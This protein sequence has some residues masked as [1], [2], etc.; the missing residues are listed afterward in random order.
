MV[1]NFKNVTIN[2]KIT[3]I[4]RR[5]HNIFI[6]MPPYWK[7]THDFYKSDFIFVILG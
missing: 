1:V 2:P 4:Y 3:M 5:L 7:I 6:N